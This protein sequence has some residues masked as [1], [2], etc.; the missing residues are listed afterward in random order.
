MKKFRKKFA[1]LFWAL[2]CILF[3]VIFFID[4]LF[5]TFNAAKNKNSSTLTEKQP[6]I[7][8]VAHSENLALH[9]FAYQLTPKSGA[10]FFLAKSNLAKTTQIQKTIYIPVEYQGSTFNSNGQINFNNLSVDLPNSKEY[11]HVAKVYSIK[12]KKNDTN[13]Q[14]FGRFDK[15]GY[16]KLSEFK[17]EK[18]TK[19]DLSK[20]ADSNQLFLALPDQRNLD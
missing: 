15:K 19:M 4:L 3:I 7:T 5:I 18:A 13:I 16:L 10:R 1:P 11:L 9:S 2:F 6:R 12:S 17:L 20:K 8:H 14:I